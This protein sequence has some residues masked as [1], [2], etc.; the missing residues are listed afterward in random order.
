MTEII[1]ISS[2]TQKDIDLLAKMNLDLYADSDHQRELSIEQMKHRFELY[3]K[4]QNGW[5]VDLLHYEDQI[6]GYCL[7][8]YEVDDNDIYVRH[9]W[10]CDEF[11]G[12]NLSI[13]A[14]ETLER[15]ESWQGRRI[16]LQIFSTNNRMEK[17]W[18]LKGFKPRSI[19]LEKS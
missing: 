17:Y 8:R 4:G 11:R 14:L 1:K 13:K 16:R 9:F 7:W 12:K 6:L 15:T 18:S 2:A 10:V 3:I 5:K 19:L